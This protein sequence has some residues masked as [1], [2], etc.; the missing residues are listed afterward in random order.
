MDFKAFFED[1]P[2]ILADAVI[3]W[4]AQ[5]DQYTVGELKKAQTQK[6]V[7]YCKALSDTIKA[8]EKVNDMEDTERKR[9]DG[10][11]KKL[12]FEMDTKPG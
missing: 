11:L 7:Q 2:S 12:V 9:I 6:A 5:Y 10:E 8:Q 1:S 4:R 3:K